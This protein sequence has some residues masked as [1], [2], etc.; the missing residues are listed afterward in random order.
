MDLSKYVTEKAYIPPGSASHRRMITIDVPT[1]VKFMT[2]LCNRIPCVQVVAVASSIKFKGKIGRFIVLF[3]L[4]VLHATPDSFGL[5][6][7]GKWHSFG[8]DC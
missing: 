3:V 2:V 5:D 8:F 7:W 1:E 6:D 4:L